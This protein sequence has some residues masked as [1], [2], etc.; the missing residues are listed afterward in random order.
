M[1]TRLDHAEPIIEPR[2]VQPLSLR[3]RLALREFT[4]GR[5]SLAESSEVAGGTLSGFV[6]LLEHLEAGRITLD[7]PAL[8]AS[9][10]TDPAPRIS[11]VIPV[12]N[13]QDNLGV[14][15][16]RL[17]R[18]LAP[19][20]SY[21]VL[22]V[23]DGS[24][25]AS[26]PIILDLQR[27]DAGVKL[28]RFS[29]N[30]GHQAAITAGIDAARGDA[31]ILMDSDLQ[32]PPEVLPRLVEQWEQGFEV[33]YAVRERRDEG[34]IKRATASVFYRTLRALAD[35]DIPVD[36]GDFCLL[37]RK[38][39]DVLRSLPEKSR[40]L[41]GLRSWAG[42][43]QV[44]VPYARPARHAGEAKYTARKM[45][46]LAFD[47][48]VSFTNLPLKLAS[49]LGFGTAFAGFTYLALAV[50]SRLS[51]GSLPQGWTALVAIIL[52]LGGAQ[53]IVM[54]FLGSYIARIYEETK[55]RPMYVVAE[56][57][58]RRPGEPAHEDTRP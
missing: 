30:F 20:G 36:S 40:F 41:R 34:I 21:E 18:V 27:Q 58:R 31:V 15:H 45:L 6:A 29:R 14:L 2:A 17:S 35:V 28:L 39:A 4:E 13:E 32:D 10:E 47:G 44:G 23:D 3:E 48:I 37:D 11:V 22:F 26:V 19:L 7:T 38:V 16:E 5:L 49:F 1:S 9:E 8:S 25:D 56:T 51:T 52:I 12:Y 42:F 43:R 54:G 24:A 46:K 33:V 55:G 53:L 50:V 57:V